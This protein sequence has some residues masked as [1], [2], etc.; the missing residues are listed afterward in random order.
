MAAT[1]KIVFSGKIAG[2]VGISDSR[3]GICTKS[4]AYT[5]VFATMAVFRGKLSA[6]SVFAPKTVVLLFVNSEIGFAINRPQIRKIQGRKLTP[7]KGSL[8]F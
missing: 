2:T 7:S 6:D 4:W 8:C 3:F 5:N 1:V